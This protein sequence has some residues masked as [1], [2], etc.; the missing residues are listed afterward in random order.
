MLARLRY[1]GEYLFG[2]NMLAYATAIGMSESWLVHVLRNKSRVRVSTFTQFVR[3]GLVSA[4]WL[5]CGTGPMLMSNARKD[6][7][8]GFVAPTAIST[9]YKVFN[10]AA[11]APK[12]YN[13]NAVDLV[14]PDGAFNAAI[15][16]QC[17]VLA[18][19]V[20]ISGKNQKPIIM[21]LPASIFTSGVAPVIIK[22]LQRKYITAIATTLAGAERDYICAGGE[23]LGVIG[24][25]IARGANAGIGFGES[26]GRFAY[27]EEMRKTS[28]L[29]A[30]HDLNVPVTVHGALGESCTHF[31]PAK[32]GVEF[33]AAFGAVSYV[34]SL[35]FAEQV[36]Q[37]AGDKH[38]LFINVGTPFPG[39]SLLSYAIRAAQHTG[40]LC[41]KRL[42]L[43]RLS[44]K[45]VHSD[46][47]ICISAP[48]RDLF[49]ALLVACDI[50][51]EG[52]VFDVFTNKNTGEQ[53]IAF[54]FPKRSADNARKKPKAKRKH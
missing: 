19:Q 35:V 50:I 30:A 53:F 45:P 52:D 26:M 48:Y 51:Y 42:K 2:G 32:N 33:G 16:K 37:M 3:S 28:V 17:D 9:Q 10:T 40:D 31:Y 29:A 36:R 46:L 27:T 18:R 20:F 11:V 25:V 22:M 47:D 23:D 13:K 6:D 7:I 4:E 34:D 54:G 49:P 15:S 24:E 21:F 38:S 5:F 1:V 39:L 8:K 12:P 43:A 41:F 14:F 44:A